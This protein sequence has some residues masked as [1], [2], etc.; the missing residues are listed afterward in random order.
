MSLQVNL[1]PLPPS[2]PE[3]EL[4]EEA[5]FQDEEARSCAALGFHRLYRFLSS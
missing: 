3:Q 2:S 5:R 1:E 4:L